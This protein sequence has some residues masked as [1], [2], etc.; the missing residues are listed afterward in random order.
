MKKRKRKWGSAYA[1]LNL[2]LKGRNLLWKQRQQGITM[3]LSHPLDS[4][5]DFKLQQG[6][7]RVKLSIISNL[8]AGFFSL[9]VN[10]Q[11]VNFIAQQLFKQT[12]H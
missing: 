7:F 8:P 4:Q 5:Q 2:L 9:Q 3:V 1:F 10:E 12:K 6:F 11:K